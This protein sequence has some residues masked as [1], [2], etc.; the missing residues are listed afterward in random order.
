MVLR[1]EAIAMLVSNELKRRDF[2]ITRDD[3]VILAENGDE[4]IEI[5]VEEDSVSILLH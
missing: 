5:V 4:L 2:D 3:N 1:P